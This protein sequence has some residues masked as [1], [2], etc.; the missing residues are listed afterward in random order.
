MAPPTPKAD[1][2][3]FEA[4]LKGLVAVLSLRAI[5]LLTLCGAFALAMKAMTD[6]TGMSLGVLAI[7]CL[8]AIFPVAYLEIR[9]HVT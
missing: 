9:R 5:L 7:Y 8:C 6:Q 2:A 1:P 4:M 3:R